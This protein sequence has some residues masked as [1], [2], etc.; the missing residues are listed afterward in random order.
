MT[1]KRCAGCTR[2]ISVTAFSCEYCG[3]VC[4]DVMDF[5]P[6]DDA[7]PDAPARIDPT[8]HSEAPI[9]EDAAAFAFGSERETADP[10]HGS[11]SAGFTS[12]LLMAAATSEPL[13]AAFRDLDGPVVNSGPASPNHPA[14]QPPLE[15]RQSAEASAK[16]EGWSEPDVAT[17]DYGLDFLDEQPAAGNDQESSMPI[18]TPPAPA[19][20]NN[21]TGAQAKP[22]GSRMGTRQLAMVGGGV[23]AA[24]ALIFTILGMRG[25][26][27]PEPAAAPAPAR[28]APASAPARSK[29]APAAAAAVKPVTV[30]ADAPRWSRVNDGRW[31]GT[32]GQTAAF[33]LSATGRVHVWM[34]DVTPVLV[35][36][37]EKGNAEAFVYI[38]SAARMEPQDGD[39]TVQV[40]FDGA[41]PASQRWPDSAEHDAL[42]ARNAPEFTR[43]LTQSRT[44]QFGF[45]PHN[46]EPVVATFVL[47]GLEPLLA[48]SAKLCGWR[49]E[50][51]KPGV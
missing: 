29:A 37:C 33:E 3:Q 40:S 22:A 14:D 7:C 35:V 12:E 1:W 15:L 8:A 43:Q 10:A 49:T 30:D 13:T 5:L 48:S 45:T 39:H 36:R 32:R 9:I 44:L 16:T 50:K 41:G 25:A 42:F 51:K 18:E 31:V 24:G 20:I 2:A 17:H 47:D 27:S 23:L 46:A 26:A 4:E 19:A 6:L 28:R 34:R 38:Q 21:S 11:G